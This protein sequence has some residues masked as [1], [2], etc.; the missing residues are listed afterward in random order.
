MISV[1][2]EK[3]MIELKG[4]YTNAIIYQNPEYVEEA[5][6]DQ[7][8]TLIDSPAYEGCKVRIMPDTHFGCSAPI[9]FTST[10]RDRV[11]P[12]TVSV[13]IGC[14][15]S[16]VSLKGIKEKDIDFFKLDDFIRTHIPVGRNIRDTKIVSFP[17][18]SHIRCYRE[19]KDSGKFEKSLGTLGGG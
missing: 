16:L 17:G 15:M 11:I 8:Q 5:C 18:M 4:K 1:T 6:L 7:I 3:D 9:G 10:I 14:G 2:E 12:N 13:D 19:L